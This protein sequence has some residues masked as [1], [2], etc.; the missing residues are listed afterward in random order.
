[1]KDEKERER[2]GNTEG[3]GNS[4]NS[5]GKLSEYKWMSSTKKIMHS[6]KNRGA[7]TEPCRGVRVKEKA[8]DKKPAN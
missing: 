2:K 5:W 7:R 3:R 6:E 4:T 1:M 8:K